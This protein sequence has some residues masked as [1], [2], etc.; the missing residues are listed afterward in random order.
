QLH[1]VLKKNLKNTIKSINKGLM[2]TLAA[3]GDVC[4]N[5]M[6]NPFIRDSNIAKEVNKIANEI[7]QNLKPNTKA[8]HEIWLDKKKVAG[9]IDSEPL[10]GNTYL[11]RKFKVAIAIPPLN[12]VDIFAHCCGLI[13]IVENNKL[14][15][16][17][18]TLGGG[19]GVTHGNHKTFPRLADVIGFCSSKNAAKVIEKIL[20]VQ[21]LY[22][23]R[24][25][26]KN[27]RLKYT[28]ETYGVKW[29][30]EKIEELLDF[31]LEKQRPFFFNSTVEKYGWRKNIDKWD[32][33]LF[34]ENGCIED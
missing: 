17:N 34:L 30:K 26:R 4:R 18:V 2:N 22:G 7:S 24:K 8:Y 27:A 21:K 9:T 32:Y 5:V 1:G 16:W 19:M 20:I 33:V 14:I 6:G 31:K 3:C 12:D 11:P 28:V 15:G 29:Y 25:N 13:A 10:Y 23:N